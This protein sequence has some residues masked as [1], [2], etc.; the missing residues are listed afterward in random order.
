M[1]DDKKLMMKKTYKMRLT[2]TGTINLAAQLDKRNT[3]KYN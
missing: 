2:N 3:T 1:L